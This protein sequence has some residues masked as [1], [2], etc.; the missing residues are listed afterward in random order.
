M[1]PRRIAH[2]IW[3]SSPKEWVERV[4]RMTAL[5]SR[6]AVEV[7]RYVWCLST[8]R[9]GTQ[10]LAALAGL[11][12][13]VDARHEPTPKLYGLSKLSYE[14]GSER[15][16]Q[17]TICEALRSCR[18]PVKSK[19]KEVYLEA[20]PQ[21]TFLAEA[22]RELFPQ[23][24]FIHLVRHPGDVMRS[25]MRRGWYVDHANDP[26]R[27]TPQDGGQAAAWG[28]WSTLEKNA[29][30][31]AE[32]NRWIGEFMGS[33]PPGDGLTIRSEEL[34]S[35]HSEVIGSFFNHLGVAQPSSHR[36]ER[37]LGHRLNSQKAGEAGEY[38][39][40]S[41]WSAEEIQMVESHAGELMQQLGYSNLSPE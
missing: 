4:R 1:K 21:G 28:S 13:G 35:A 24:R 23:S 18:P 33:L 10:T 37:V 40:F 17:K 3:T 14:L 2:K 25:G 30:L 9:V 22:L 34:F 7:E 27:I 38:P 19:H 12:D 39:K 15:A 8:G 26:W 20:S 32:T 31:W 36:I 11:V 16:G 41:D 29:W 6:D 5:A